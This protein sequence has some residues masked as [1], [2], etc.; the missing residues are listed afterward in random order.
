MN[1]I[2]VIDQILAVL[3]DHCK[4]LAAALQ[5]RQ[6]AEIN[7]IGE[8]SAVF[9]ALHWQVDDEIRNT[10]NNTDGEDIRGFTLQFPIHFK[11]TTAGGRKCQL[12]PEVR[13]LV[14]V[15]QE[16]IE[17]DPTLQNTALWTE[18]ISTRFFLHDGG[19]V[20]GAIVTYHITYRRRRAQ[21]DISY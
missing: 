14:A 2:P 3:Q 6:A 15:L 10:E 13:R 4:E 12:M 21:P 18:Y 8:A 16:K 11:I 1:N 19:A 5:F 17:A 9:P 20:G 7:D